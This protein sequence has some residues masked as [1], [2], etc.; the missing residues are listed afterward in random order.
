MQTIYL[1]ISNK[2]VMPTIYAK[3]GDV[4]RKFNAFLTDSGVPCTLNGYA[5]S[6]WYEGDS[7]EGNYNYIGDKSAFS[8][9]ENTVSVEMITQMLSTP[10]DGEMCL[11]LSKPDGGQVASWNIPYICEEVPGYGS[12]EAQEYFTAFSKAVEDLPYPDS[13]LS[14][15]GK[16]A[17][18]AAVGSL[19]INGKSIRENPVLSAEDVGA[20]DDNWFPTT[21]EIG[22]VP[23]HESETYPGCFYRT[24][25]EEIEWINPPVVLGEEYR[26]TE[27][28]NGHAVYT[29]LIN[30]GKFP[31][32][33]IKG[34][35]HNLN[36]SQV[37][38][39]IGMNAEYFGI[40][41]P[42]TEPGSGMLIA[43]AWAHKTT[44]MVRTNVQIWTDYDC[45]VQLWYT[46]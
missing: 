9:N 22:A 16:S 36:I 26:T 15:E 25:G 11:V 44:V 46:K 37:V 19:T 18:A 24:V 3:Q 31:S 21:E 38:R 39:C 35:T 28:W 32:N 14:V 8:I 13:S 29:T 41:L 1:D 2:G 12:E 34:I 7:G 10:G 23:A 42:Y 27:R 20:R 40:V 30:C 6:V 33:S 43:D 4:G 45:Y 5:F 17:D